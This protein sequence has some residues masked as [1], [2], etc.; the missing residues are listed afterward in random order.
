MA[1]GRLLTSLDGHFLR[2]DAGRYRVERNYRLSAASP[3]PADVYL[4]GGT[5]HTHGL[6]SSLLSN[7]A[8]RSGEIVESIVQRGTERELTRSLPVAAERAGG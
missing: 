4:Q 7:L 8:V 5:E 1:P 6:T 2:D 3:L